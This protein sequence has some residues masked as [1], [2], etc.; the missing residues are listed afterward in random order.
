MNKLFDELKS[1]LTLI[2]NTNLVSLSLYGSLAWGDFDEDSSDIDCLVVTQVDVNETE[3][4][5]LT[6]MHHHLIKKFPRFE[7]RLEIAYF[8]VYTLNS[9]Q[10]L[11]NKI[12]IISPGEPFTIKEAGLDWLINLYLIHKKSLALIGPNPSSFIRGIPQDEFLMAVK[13]QAREWYD[14]IPHTKESRSYQAHAVLTLCRAFYTIEHGEQVSKKQ[15]AY[16][17]K[18]KYPTWATLIE[19]ALSWRTDW[20]SKTVNPHETYPEVEAFVRQLISTRFK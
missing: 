1:R 9:F 11:K 12:A 19:K 17:A 10:P 20:K 7:S 16:W 18:N 13:A 6:D 14:W 4:S 15:A 5:R 2:L 8:S 3:F